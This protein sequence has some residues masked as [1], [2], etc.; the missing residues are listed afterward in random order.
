MKTMFMVDVKD[1]CDFDR[2]GLRR[3]FSNRMDAEACGTNQ[4]ERR[5]EKEEYQG[6]FYEVHEIDIGDGNQDLIYAN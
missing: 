5:N 3:L 2:L 1:G 6:W 4:C